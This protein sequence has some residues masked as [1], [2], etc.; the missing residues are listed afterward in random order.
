MS[1]YTII[2]INGREYDVTESE[3]KAVLAGRGKV[4][5]Q[6]LMVFINTDSISSTEPKGT[7]RQPDREK[8]IRG[9]LHD[10]GRVVRKFGVWFD[11][12]NPEVR[13]DPEYY[14][15]VAG[16]FVVTP[17]EFE[18]HVKAIESRDGRL[19]AMRGIIGETRSSEGRM[20]IAGKTAL[21][22]IASMLPEASKT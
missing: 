19:D 11:A 22:P 6:R 17:E 13:I 10:G 5:V 2:M 18:E 14:P 12:N 16:D 7:G 4:W 1:M 20:R 21:E 8:Q 9:M 3:Y 15:E